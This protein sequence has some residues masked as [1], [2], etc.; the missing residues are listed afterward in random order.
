ML[1]RLSLSRTLGA[2]MIGEFEHRSVVSLTSSNRCY[3]CYALDHPPNL[4][5]V[6]WTLILKL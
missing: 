3:K 6:A 4:L 1:M 5:S 2:V